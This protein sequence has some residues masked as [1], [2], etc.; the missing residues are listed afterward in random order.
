MVS[1]KSKIPSSKK[2]K[3]DQKQIRRNSLINKVQK[4]KK[5]KKIKIKYRKKIELKKI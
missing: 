5:R 1:R 2:I 4:R 3:T